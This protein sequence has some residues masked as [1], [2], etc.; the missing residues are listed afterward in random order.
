M[1]EGLSPHT[2]ARRPRCPTLQLDLEDTQENLEQA[3]GELEELRE[4]TRYGND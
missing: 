3:L 2:N 1:R 4:E